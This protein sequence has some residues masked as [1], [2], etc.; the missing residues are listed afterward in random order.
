[1]WEGSISYTPAVRPAGSGVAMRENSL[2]MWRFGRIVEGS[3][4][5]DDIQ[6]N[7]SRNVFLGGGPSGTIGR[8]RW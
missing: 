1:M 7:G 2:V 6:H 8:K 5:Y 3:T 4:T